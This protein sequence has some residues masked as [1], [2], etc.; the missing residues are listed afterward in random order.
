MR[1]EKLP[2]PMPTNPDKAKGK[3]LS[4]SVLKINEFFLAKK[5]CEISTSYDY[6]FHRLFCLIQFHEKSSEKVKIEKLSI[7]FS[8]IELLNSLT[9]V[10]WIMLWTNWTT[11][12]LMAVRSDLLRKAA[13]VAVPVAVDLVAAVPLLDPGLVPAPDPVPSPGHAHPPAGAVLD[14]E[15]RVK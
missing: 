6:L 5:N 13:E 15:D 1:L 8:L 2:T 9:V 12:N 14:P 3:F 10:D 7:I 4:I 11:L